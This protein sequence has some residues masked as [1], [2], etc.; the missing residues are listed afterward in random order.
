MPDQDLLTVR[1]VA[2][3]LQ[4]KEATI[5]TWAQDGK[6]PA[7]KAGRNWQFRESDLTRWL[8]GHL[9]PQEHSQV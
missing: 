7:I 3:F 5:Y 1:Q 4:L 8:E 9:F 6:I 2:R